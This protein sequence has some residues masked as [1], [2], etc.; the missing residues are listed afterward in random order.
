MCGICGAI[1]TVPDKEIDIT[2]LD[3]MTDRLTH[4]G[5][6]D[7]GTLILKDAENPLMPN[8]CFGFR[9][10]SILDLSK[11]G[12][13]PMTN[14]DGTIW[15]VFNGEIYNYET[16][17]RELIEK[18]HQFKSNTDTEVL[19]H[20]YEE[21]QEA[22]LQ[23]L[24]GMFG[25]A[26]WDTQRKRMFF[27]RDRI[28]KK[29]LLYR[30][31]NGRFIFASELK[32]ILAIPDIPK[33]IDPVALDEYLTYQYVPH[34]KSI[35]SGISKLPP[36]HYGIWEDCKLTIKSY[37][38]PDF[39]LQD[40]NITVTEW[41]DKIRE[42]L[43]DA[44]KIRLRSDVPLGAFLSG[45]IDSS[46]IAGIMQREY[47]QRVKTFT[48]G[49]TDKLFD[50]TEYARAAATKFGTSHREFII[51]ED[52]Q[53]IIPKLVWFYDEPFA[54]QSVIPTWHLCE[55]TRREV[56]VALSGDGGDELFAGYDRH[57]AAHFGKQFDYLPFFIR[58][59]LSNTIVSM[60]PG[61]S[62]QKSFFRRLQRFLEG[63]DLKQS[64]RF[65]QWLAVF[66]KKQ[67]Y[68][69]YTNEFLRNFSGI[70]SINYLSD[71][72]KKCEKRDPAT[73]LSL[74]DLQT[75]LPAIMTKVDISSMAHSL[76]CRAPFLDHRVVECAIKTP[77][78]YKIHGN[79]GKMILR[80]AFKDILPSVITHRRDK[81]GFG[82][83][84]H[85]WFRGGFKNTMN[86]IL[87]D[88][89][90]IQRGFFRCEKIETILTE[91]FS[92]RYDHSKQIWA[93]FMLEMWIR[94]W[95]E[96]KATL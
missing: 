87:L 96:G 36:A 62:T 65:I 82:G 69:L 22:M 29:P 92:N 4:R 81:M 73:Q 46:I 84:T 52:I 49:Y 39:N 19:I 55:Q 7:R 12:H 47:G 56:T 94:T 75:Y 51:T 17:R 25:F 44:V 34:H 64:E 53:S 31:E 43:I 9:R 10:L 71:T 18:G 93:L 21:E 30:Q 66:N 28:G 13:Q 35:L 27:A 37:W 58:K 83:P 32:S 60:I 85:Q 5:P 77:I 45:G 68:E 91:H 74:T 90:T 79:T 78:R 67:R 88:T 57:R 42:L 95:V 89:K 40:D 26:I 23:K 8:V 14:E 24:N 15:I 61:S 86:D 41:T 20:L 2:T 38:N 54:D 76:E 1:W 3:R 6:D 16:L 63:L 72:I 70:D 50:E 80:N 48:I 59:F 33:V 11:N